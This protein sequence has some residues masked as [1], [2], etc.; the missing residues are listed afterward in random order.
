MNKQE[1]YD[2]VA[3]HLLTQRAKSLHSIGKYESVKGCAYRGDEGRTCAVGCLIADKYYDPFLEEKNI[4]SHSVQIALELSGVD[5]N[6]VNLLAKLQL[7]HDDCPVE[8][9]ETRL[10]AIAD[11]EGLTFKGVNHE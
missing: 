11:S 9:W 6:L 4:R 10:R 5:L 2:K 3:S 8:D 1:T 7:V